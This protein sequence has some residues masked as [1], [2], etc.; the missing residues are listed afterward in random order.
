MHFRMAL[1]EGDV[2]PAH[3]KMH[4][5]V[6]SSHVFR[7]AFLLYPQT[8]IGLVPSCACR[9][10]HH[11]VHLGPAAERVLVEHRSVGWTSFCVHGGVGVSCV[12]QDRAVGC[13]S[14][15]AL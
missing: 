6:G 1:H 8:S 14:P 13:L 11:A 2:L 15:R 12:G 3:L 4:A 10:L 9:A 7:D 5:V